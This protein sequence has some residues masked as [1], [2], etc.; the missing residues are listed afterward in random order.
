MKVLRSVGARAV[1]CLAV[2]AALSAFSDA[3]AQQ[4]F[5]GRDALWWSNLGQQVSASLNLPVA[6]IQDQ[7]LQHIIFFATNYPLRVDFSDAVS[8]ILDIYENDANEGRRTLALAA[9]HALGNDY[10]MKRLSE[11]VQWESS[12]RI[13]HLTMVVLAEYYRKHTI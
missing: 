9:L 8:N 11:V 10:A 4:A 3:R 7:S 6:Q 5:E 1:V 13:H 12:T 2:L